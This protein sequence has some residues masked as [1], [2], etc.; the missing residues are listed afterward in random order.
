MAA[1]AAIAQERA[2]EAAARVKPAAAQV[3]PLA[4]TTQEAARRGL[5]QTRTWAAPRVE[6]TIWAAPRIEHTGQVLQDDVAPKVADT[7]SSAAR[8]I[9]PEKPRS[10]NWWTLSGIAI[11]LAAAAAA[12]AA[13]LRKRS[14]AASTIRRR[15]RRD[16]LRT[17]DTSVNPT[18]PRRGRHLA[19][20][21]ARLTGS[22]TGQQHGPASA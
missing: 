7:L 18:R 16:G 4:K 10:R 12:A 21:A 1:A 20:P 13:A 5:V 3:K 8:R 19:D 15:G 22:T 9:E 6:R 17:P 11:L 2:R 14:T